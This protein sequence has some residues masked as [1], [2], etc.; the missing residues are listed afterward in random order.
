MHGLRKKLVP[1]MI[2]R[3]KE[4]GGDPNLA[5]MFQAETEAVGGTARL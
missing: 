1:F 2:K 3:W 4:R 5:F